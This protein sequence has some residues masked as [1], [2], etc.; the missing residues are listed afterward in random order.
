MKA[1]I[2]NASPRKAG[3]TS[4]VL[5]ILEKRIRAEYDTERID[6]R[7]LSVRPCEGCSSCRPNGACVLPRDGAHDIGEKIA[8]ADLIVIGTPCYWGNIPSPLKAI[9]DR[10]VTTFEHFLSGKPEPKLRGK[11][12]I[13][14]VTSGSSFPFSHLR[15]QIGGTV[16]ALKT[17]LKSG[18]IKILSVV[19]IPSAWN[20]DAAI[21]S[22]E[23]KI[24]RARIR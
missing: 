10:N 16:N 24:A 15:T 13:I 23:R 5:G 21:P 18:G 6:V 7:D 4:A 3:S 12:A 9:L 8:A 19:S 17:V 1:L 11:K 14:V 20:L 22:A 2:L